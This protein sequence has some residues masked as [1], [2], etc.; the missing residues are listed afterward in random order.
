LQP[1]KRPLI[2]YFHLLGLVFL[3][4]ISKFFKLDD[5]YH[6]ERARHIR[7]TG[8]FDPAY[9]LAQNSDVAESG[10]DPLLHYVTYG[11]QEGRKPTLFF[12][13]KIYR[14]H[15][16]TFKFKFIEINTLL[17]YFAVGRHYQISTS[18]WIDIS[19]YLS[20]NRDVKINGIEPITHYVKY[21]GFEGRS[22]SLHFDSRYYLMSN[23]D[24]QASGVNPLVHYVQ[25]GQAEGRKPNATYVHVDH[26][27]PSE[28]NG[29]HTALAID[30]IQPA[31]RSSTPALI[32]VIIPVYENR[33]LTMQCIAS[34]LQAK[35]NVSFEL[36]VINDHSPNTEIN[37]DLKAM[38]QKHWFTLIN[39]E[40]NSGFVYTVNKGIKLH[41]DRDIII[42]NSDTEVYDFWIDRLR[43]VAYSRPKVASVTPLSNNATICSYPRFLYDNPYPLE[44]SYA[45][46]D[47]IASVVNS[48]ISVEAPTGIGFC[49]FMRRNVITQIGI[50]DQDTFGIGY[51]EENDWCQRALKRGHVNLLAPNIFVRH[52]GNASFQGSKN[53]R[54]THAINILSKKYPRY[55]QDIQRFIKTD[56]MSVAR[57]RL[58]WARLERLKG[59]SNIVI[60]CHQRGGGTERHIQEAVKK[61]T[62][63]GIN[64]FFMRPALGRP[65]HVK[66][67]HNQ[68][69]ELPSIPDIALSDYIQLVSVIQRLDIT[70]IH[71]HGQV[72]F[73]AEASIHLANICKQINIPLHIT[74]HDY[75]VVCPR[76]NLI[77]ENGLYCGEP[78]EKDCNKCLNQR[79]NDFNVK[80]ISV[81][82]KNNYQMLRYALSIQVPNADCQKRIHQ[83][84]PDLQ[85]D[86]QPHHI[87]LLKINNELQSSE[88]SAKLRVLVIGAIGKMK[89]FDV[90][91][92]C[93]RLVQE[94]HLPIELILMGYSMDDTALRQQGVVVMGKYDESQAAQW[95]LDIKPDMVWLPSIWPETFSY[96]LSIGLEAGVPIAAFDIG[97]IAD[98]LK[99]LELDQ[100]LMP[101]SLVN[102]PKSVI[103]KLL[104]R[105]ESKND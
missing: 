79:G 51:G 74:I 103:Q 81:W 20:S 35:S 77:D 25:Y 10:V 44:V 7:E 50:F 102:E 19:Y 5:T 78:Q 28:Q 91:L 9:Y 101:L 46:L 93:A 76:I 83:Y 58:D 32:D 36:I 37:Q 43:E 40:T 63:N 29:Y 90:L 17:H 53:S 11:D 67:K 39:N 60:F 96:T 62:A 65:S 4:T 82:R 18:E 54:V 86:I 59:Q 13:P 42:L 75:A 6:R 84:F 12:D 99:A 30:D 71:V 31:K 45:E 8:L 97:A 1:G 34:V 95:V 14:T 89:G 3:K 73:E 66:I 55:E 16:N 15:A 80:D 23:P 68:C 47:N 57:E 100:Y 24:V 52:F 87:D 85:I 105:R 94:K 2:N 38:A 72:D 92:A 88:K 56:E 33:I 21:G 70:E 41:P 22:P 49:M 61:M 48:N 64:V 69:N 98:R 104:T 27:H 26:A